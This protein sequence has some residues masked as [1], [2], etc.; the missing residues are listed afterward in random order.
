MF[1]GF[2]NPDIGA[3]HH[4]H[5]AGVAIA[6]ASPFSSPFIRN[7]P[8][9]QSMSLRRERDVSGA[10][11]RAPTSARSPGREVSGRCAVGCGDQPVD[12]FRRQ[13][14]RQPRQPPVRHRWYCDG[15]IVVAFSTKVEES[16]K[17]MKR[18]DQRY[19]KH[20]PLWLACSRR[21]FR[22]ACAF[23]WYDI[24]AERPDHP[25]ETGA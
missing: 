16:Y 20:V 9:F 2:G 15:G 24:L 11:T 7:V 8:L 13:T 5:P 10:Q 19:L 12:L 6:P 4:R 25:R 3:A 18:G 22:T 1:V 21:K 14:T 17:C 23:H